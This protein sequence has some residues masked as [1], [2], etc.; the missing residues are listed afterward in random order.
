MIDIATKVHLSNKPPKLFFFNTFCK[1]YSK[2]SRSSWTWS[3]K[4][5][6]SWTHSLCLHWYLKE[7]LFVI[8]VL[9]LRPFVDVIMTGKSKV[10]QTSKCNFADKQ[11]QTKELLFVMPRSSA[12]RLMW[13]LCGKR[14]KHD[15]SD[16]RM[17]TASWLYL[18]VV[19]SNSSII[20]FAQKCH[21]WHQISKV[22]LSG[23]TQ[24][25]RNMEF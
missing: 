16:T 25:I 12:A 15:Y 1:L 17:F 5:K 11:H 22:K 9:H 20:Y 24:V 21:T 13:L 23:F 2:Y 7:T 6:K 14:Q 10:N 18:P 4:E 19:I 8:P 3:S